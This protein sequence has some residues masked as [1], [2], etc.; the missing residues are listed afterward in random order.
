MDI[1][2]VVGFLVYIRCRRRGGGCRGTSEA[3]REP[4]RYGDELS[5]V[6]STYLFR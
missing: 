2:S 3:V 1:V 4:E 5:V 6:V